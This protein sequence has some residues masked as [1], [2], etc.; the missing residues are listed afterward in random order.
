MCFKEHNQER[1]TKTSVGE[2]AE[3]EKYS[4]IAYRNTKIH[5]A[6]GDILNVAQGEI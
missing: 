6:L 5:S 1:Q 4:V 3:K 2:D